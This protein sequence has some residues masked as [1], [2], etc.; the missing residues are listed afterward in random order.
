VRETWRLE[1]K[2]RHLSHAGRLLSRCALSSVGL[3]VGLWF[4]SFSQDLNVF[5][6]I[7]GWTCRWHE[8]SLY[9]I[10][11]PSLKFVGF[12]VLKIMANFRSRHEAAWWPWPLIF[13]HGNW[14][15][16]SPMARPTFLSVLVLLPLFFVELGGSTRQTY[17]IL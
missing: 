1:S 15:E 11:I 3:S 8:S 16:M 2:L 4:F 17:M 5:K 7:F 12:P 6:T 9:S 14:C 13:W 10:R